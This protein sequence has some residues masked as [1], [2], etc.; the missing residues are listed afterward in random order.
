MILCRTS[1]L[2]ISFCFLCVACR[3]PARL[4]SYC[5]TLPRPSRRMHSCLMSLRESSAVS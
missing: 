3:Q 5:K 2:W 1:D 4:K